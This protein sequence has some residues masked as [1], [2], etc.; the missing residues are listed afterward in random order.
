[1]IQRVS[2]KSIEQGL[3]NIDEHKQQAITKHEE[4]LAKAIVTTAKHS[5]QCAKHLDSQF[6]RYFPEIDDIG[7]SSEDAFN[8]TTI[9]EFRDG[10]AHQV[11]TSWDK[12]SGFLPD[13]NV[14]DTY[15]DDIKEY[16]CCG[17]CSVYHKKRWISNS[18]P[19]N[20]RIPCCGATYHQLLSEKKLLVSNFTNLNKLPECVVKDT[21]TFYCHHCDQQCNCKHKTNSS[22]QMDGNDHQSNYKLSCCSRDVHTLLK[23]NKVSIIGGNIVSFPIHFEVDNYL[24]LY[25]PQT[26]LYL[27]FNKTS[28]PLMSFHMRP[29]IFKSNLVSALVASNQELHA[30]IDKRE[31]FITKVNELIPEDYANI[32]D[33]YD[34]F[35]KFDSFTPTQSQ[36]ETNVDTEEVPDI[37][38]QEDSTPEERT[39]Q[40]LQMKLAE[41]IK[42]SEKSEKYIRDMVS[43]YQLQTVHI[44]SYK[45]EIEQ[46]KTTYTNDMEKNKHTHTQAIDTLTSTHNHEIANLQL[47]QRVELENIQMKETIAT[48]DTIED[49]KAEKF[50]LMQQLSEAEADKTKL[51]ALGQSKTMLQKNIDEQERKMKRL[52]NIN[53]AMVSEMKIIKDHNNK[54]YTDN[55]QLHSQMIESQA[56]QDVL[57]HTLSDS[58]SEL[59][60]KEAENKQLV[61]MFSQMQKKETGAVESVLSDRIQDIEEEKTKLKANNIKLTTEIRQLKQ[62]M[63]KYS[64]LAIKFTNIQ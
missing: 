26:G 10:K 62:K 30:S 12:Y 42:R 60:K 6:R 55:T 44:K 50:T 37:S 31:E 19:S 7:E 46:L 18:P 57:T 36:E 28:F 61:N 15:C 32:V 41:T 54:L 45:E 38:Q 40:K 24:N 2:M 51:D 8:P 4:L 9:V 11:I 3:Y 29:K 56:K 47:E 25:Y 23:D 5:N 20:E 35:R 16:I 17:R 52:K 21:T 43:N 22:S 53:S 39:I 59:L 27:C 58:R 64:T 14:V 1:M 33:F 34:R 49:L 63:K 13:R 48:N